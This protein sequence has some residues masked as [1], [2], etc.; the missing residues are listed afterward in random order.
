MAIEGRIREL[1]SRHQHLDRAIDA[2]VRRPGADSV[3]LYEMKR[4]KL[5]LKEEI[6]VLRG[7][8]AH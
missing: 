5:K 2:E 7:A 8:R 6:E 3:A 1:D 4:Q